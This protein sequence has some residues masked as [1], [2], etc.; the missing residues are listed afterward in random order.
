MK[1][2]NTKLKDTKLILLILL[3]LFILILIDKISKSQIIEKFA[4]GNFELCREDDCKCL[5]LNTAPDGTCVSYDISKKPSVPKY[6]NKKTYMQHVVR[7]NLY[8][9]KRKLDILLFVGRGIKKMKKKYNKL[10][11]LLLNIQKVEYDR[12]SIDPKTQNLLMVFEKANKILK[13]FNNDDKPYIKYLILDIDHGGE[14]REILNSYNLTNKVVPMIYLINEASRERKYFKFNIEE[15]K[16]VL[17]KELLIFIANGDLGL[18]SYLNHL[19]DPFLGVEFLHDSEENKWYEN[20]PGMKMLDEGTEMCKLIDYRD[21]P[22]KQMEAA[23]KLS[24]ES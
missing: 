21:L 17:L 6:K 20:N 24:K 13:Y 3:I 2:N 23:I 19:H 14:S 10:P 18:I 11:N 8:P 22:K 9:M 15:D 5:K 16:C 1:K 12:H 7:N 4:E